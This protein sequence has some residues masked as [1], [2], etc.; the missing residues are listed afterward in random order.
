M[1]AATIYEFI[2]TLPKK[3][4]DLLI[5]MIEQDKLE[6]KLDD[7]LNDKP[8]KQIDNNDCFSYLLENH[9]NKISKK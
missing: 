2:K 9:F 4:W 7:F 1:T 8:C 6:F 3:E 5:D